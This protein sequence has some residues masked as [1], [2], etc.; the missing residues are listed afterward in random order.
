MMSGVE[1]IIYYGI[2][3]VAVCCLKAAMNI[4][5]CY[6]KKDL[7]RVTK[8]GCRQVGPYTVVSVVQTGSLN[9][10]SK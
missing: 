1:L 6:E 10:V 4:N 5:L 2:F 7:T 8:L 3:Y 9:G